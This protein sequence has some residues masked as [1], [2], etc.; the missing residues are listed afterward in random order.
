V[1]DIQNVL[2]AGCCLAKN[3]GMVG[4]GGWALSKDREEAGMTPYEKAGHTQVSPDDIHGLGTVDT[5]PFQ[6]LLGKK[7]THARQWW[8]IPLV[9]ALGGQRQVDL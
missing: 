7:K 3:S 8:H 9:P 2:D 6:D 5:S 4:A 1:C